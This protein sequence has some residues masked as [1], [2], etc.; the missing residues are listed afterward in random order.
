MITH[1]CPEWLEQQS[2]WSPA[3]FMRELVAFNAPLPGQLA[4]AGLGRGGVSSRGRGCGQLLHALPRVVE[5][6]FGVGGI[7]PGIRAHVSSW[8]VKVDLTTVPSSFVDF[9]VFSEAGVCTVC[10]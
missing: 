5:T 3:G 10:I 1:S 4:E 2:E 6:V 8:A 9:G 7:V